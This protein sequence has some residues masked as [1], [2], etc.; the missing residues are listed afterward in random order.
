MKKTCTCCHQEK[1]LMDF[2][3]KKNGKFGKHA[4][5]KNCHKGKSAKWKENNPDRVRINQ[6]L[7]KERLNS[8]YLDLDSK[9]TLRL[10]EKNKEGFERYANTKM[11]LLANNILNY[12]VRKGYIEKSNICSLCKIE[13]D[14]EGHHDDYSKPLQVTWVCHGCHVLIHRNKKFTKKE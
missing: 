10:D 1:R 2:Y 8:Q 6:T 4:I 14:I 12:G 11:R 7:Y 9:F 3:N 5:C 13:I